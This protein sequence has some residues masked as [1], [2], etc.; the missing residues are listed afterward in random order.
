MV[1]RPHLK[2]LAFLVD[3]F[4]GRFSLRGL[5]ST[6]KNFNFINLSYFSS[7]CHEKVINCGKKGVGANPLQTQHCMHNISSM[8]AASINSIYN[9]T[10]WTNMCSCGT[11]CIPQR[12]R[13]TM[14]N[15]FCYCHSPCRQMVK[16]LVRMHSAR[17]TKFAPT[18]I[19]YKLGYVQI[20]VCIH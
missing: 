19:D 15:V 10:I 9:G 13:P 18:S 16:A 5:I 7:Y 11:K 3:A 14:N 1:W 20:I 17:S 2:H 12:H 6:K 8:L 4:W